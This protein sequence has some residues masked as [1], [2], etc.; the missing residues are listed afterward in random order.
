MVEVVDTP[1]G[2]RLCIRQGKELLS[3]TIVHRHRMRL[4]D[5]TLSVGAI[6]DVFTWERVRGKGYAGRLLDEALN[7]MAEHG[8]ALSCVYGIPDLYARRGFRTCA[9]RHSVHVRTRDLELHLHNERVPA[10]FSHRLGNEADRIRILRLYNADNRHRTGTFVRD[11][12]TWSWFGHG[13]GGDRLPVVRVIED[14]RGEID[15]Y[16]VYDTDVTDELCVLELGCA[17][18]Q[19]FPLLLR[20]LAGEAARRRTQWIRFLTPADHPVTHYLKYVGAESR[21]EYPADGSVMA[22]IVS[23]KA[24]MDA[25]QDLFA[26]RLR[27]SPWRGRSVRCS[28][29]TDLGVISFAWDGTDLKIKVADAGS[30]HSVEAPTI[31]RCPQDLFVVALLGYIPGDA[32]NY[33]GGW[34]AWGEEALV[35]HMFPSGE[36]F[37]W[38]TDWY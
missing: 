8:I 33:L 7:L 5:A 23:L 15:A 25:V 3:Q 1:S 12:D 34:I 16:A 35:R 13:L 20:L 27:Q 31:A 10:I 38:Q 36:P 17:D 19:R 14:A 29:E 22:R 6:T 2:W 37:F 9:A 28:I 26:R 32:W 21:V 18:W 4:E 11:E 24:T 30:A